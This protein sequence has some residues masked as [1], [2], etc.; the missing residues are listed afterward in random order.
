MKVENRYVKSRNFNLLKE[1][2]VRRNELNSLVSTEGTE[3]ERILA[4]S[5]NLDKILLEY[6]KETNN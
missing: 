5:R 6:I 4:V 1:I 2:E 3:S